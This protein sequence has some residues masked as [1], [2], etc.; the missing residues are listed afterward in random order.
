MAGIRMSTRVWP[1]RWQLIK[2]PPPP[3]HQLPVPERRAAG[4]TKALPQLTCRCLAGFVGARCEVNVDDC[5]MRLVLTA[6]HAWTASTAS[7]A[8]APRASL[9]AS[10]TINLD[11][12]A[13]RP[14]REGPAVGTGPRTL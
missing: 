2:H 11:D 12:C 3:P 5:L 8:S 9:G 1:C 13:S 14:A 10:C 4:L 6:P 7:P